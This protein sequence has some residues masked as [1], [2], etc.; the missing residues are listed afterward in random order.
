MPIKELQY[1]KKDPLEH[2]C[3]TSQSSSNINK[4]SKK[5]FI[6]GYVCL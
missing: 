2:N 6:E 4:A 1:L 3:T 5:A